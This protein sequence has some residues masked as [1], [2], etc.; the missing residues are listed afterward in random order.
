[1]KEVAAD[2]PAALDQHCTL[3]QSLQVAWQLEPPTVQQVTQLTQ[4]QDVDTEQQI[5]NL[6]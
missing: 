2:H 6:Q 4:G 3:L 5:M 1:M